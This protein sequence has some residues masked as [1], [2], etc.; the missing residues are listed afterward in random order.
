V[1]LSLRSACAGVLSAM[2]SL[3]GVVGEEESLAVCGSAARA[4]NRIGSIH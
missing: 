4:S 3:S 2:S 1:M